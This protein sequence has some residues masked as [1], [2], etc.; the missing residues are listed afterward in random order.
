MTDKAQTPPASFNIADFFTLKASNEGRDFPLILPNGEPTPY[1]LRVISRL[2][3]KAAKAIDAYR[4]D[5]L[6]NASKPE[7]ERLTDRELSLPVRAAMVIGWTLPA[8]F[9][10][11]NLIDFL[12]NAPQIAEA[13]DRFSWN[14]ANFFTKN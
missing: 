9:N 2:S 5:I 3:D 11:E 6:V 1:S 12:R 10:E 4:R 7:A 14:D 8:D 13:V